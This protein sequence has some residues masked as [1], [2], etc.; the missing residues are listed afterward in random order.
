MV[1]V[2]LRSRGCA[3]QVT[4]TANTAASGNGG[5]IA[6]SGSTL[7]FAGVSALLALG[8]PA[9]LLQRTCKG[10]GCVAMPR[11]AEAMRAGLT[12]YMQGFVTSLLQAVADALCQPP[13]RPP[14]WQGSVTSNSAHS[15]GA[16]YA[17]G[18]TSLTV[19]SAS[20]NKLW[21]V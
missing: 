3:R 11:C 19:T 18:S 13:P 14:P 17:L 9:G 7:D 16:M 21:R 15:G 4:L 2:A 12:N 5:A 1:A 8:S 20:V 6:L 10:C